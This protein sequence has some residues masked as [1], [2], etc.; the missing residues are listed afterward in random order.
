MSINTDQ[1]STFSDLSCLS[2]IVDNK[3]IPT[4]LNLN[5][6]NILPNNIIKGSN[7]ESLCSTLKTSNST[8]TTSDL[9]VNSKSSNSNTNTISSNS[10]TNTISSNSNTNTIS[11]NSNTNTISSNSNTNTRSNSNSNSSNSNSNSSNSNSNSSNS[12]S[13]TNMSWNTLNSTVIESY[14]NSFGEFLIKEKIPNKIHIDVAVVCEEFNNIELKCEDHIINLDEID[15]T[16]DMFQVMFYPYK[17]NFGLNK[18]FFI[19]NCK[20]I[21]FISFFPDFRTVNGKKFY[22]LEQIIS[23]IETDLNISR[24]CFTKDSLVELTNEIT[25]IKTLLDIKCCS[26]LSSLTWSNIIDIIRN[27][28][29]IQEEVIPILIVNIVFKTPTQG[30]KDTIIRFQYKICNNK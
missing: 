26:V 28:T 27:Y 1:L 9:T 5:K 19:N 16:M 29:L 14:K 25:S 3:N 12:N 2:K 20:F 30:V 23:N 21:P 8:V 24:H 4:N 6:D 11:S 13:N 10:N 15:V 17:E 18:D 7:T 22:L